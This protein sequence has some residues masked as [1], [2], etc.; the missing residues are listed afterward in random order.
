[1]TRASAPKN[2]RGSKPMPEER[3][4]LMVFG[5]GKLGGAVIDVL[6]AR[7]SRHKYIIISRSAERAELRLNLSRY[8]CSQ[9]GAYPDLQ[10]DTTDLL[11]SE[12]TAELLDR[13]RPDVVFNATTP[14]PWWLLDALP[15]PLR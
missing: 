6:A 11:N 7:Y 4:T 10:W 3:K 15:D 1:M 9:W 2:Q 5:V 14:F 12:R 13:H 8:T